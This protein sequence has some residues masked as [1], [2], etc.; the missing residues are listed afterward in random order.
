MK[1]VVTLLPLLMFFG[2]QGVT[3]G[4][5]RSPLPPWSSNEL[6]PDGLSPDE[7]LFRWDVVHEIRFT[8][9]PEDIQRLQN[10]PRT[11]APTTIYFDGVEVVVGMRLKGSSTYRPLSGKPSL[12]IKLDAGT[13]G[14][15]LFGVEGFNLHNQ[16]ADPSFIGEHLGYLLMREMG[17]P[18]PRTGLAAVWLGNQYKGLYT[19]TER[20]D[21][22]WIKAWY[23]DPTGSLYE[24][25][26]CDVNGGGGWGGSGVDCWEVDTVGSNDS[27]E[28]LRQF[29]LAMNTNGPTF[30]NNF[31]ANVDV[32]ITTRGLATEWVM[33]HWDSYSGNLNNYHLYHEPATGKWSLTPWS[34]DLTFGRPVGGNC[35]QT[36][37]DRGSFTTG[38]LA[39]RCSNAAA[40][41][42]LVVEAAGEVL[43][44]IDAL[45][46]DT[47]LR[48]LTDVMEPWI[49]IE[50]DP[51]VATRWQGQV[52]CSRNYMLNRRAMLG[53][54]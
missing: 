5:D 20:K 46:V 44:R 15:S 24:G 30:W 13:P 1:S 28:D 42:A 6:V 51:S 50:P 36:P 40:C 2:C 47:T 17:V 27:I 41:D 9:T 34:M 48:S 43:D 4:D 37:T 33:G 29:L 31:D 26:G 54:P 23:D 8:S 49:A 19:I 7:A 52:I 21:K 45:D 10:N 18:A 39:R 22:D 12:K 53:L 32:D 25:V 38:L 16:V 11:Y 14:Y 3:P 35:N